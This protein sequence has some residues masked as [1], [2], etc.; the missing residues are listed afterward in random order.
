M[1]FN[2][3]VCKRKVLKSF[4]NICL[5]GKKNDNYLFKGLYF[6]CMST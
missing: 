5:I 2:I 4:K 3:D 6:F 1:D